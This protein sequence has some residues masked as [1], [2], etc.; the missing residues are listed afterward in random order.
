[1]EDTFKEYQEWSDEVV[2]ETSMPQYSTALNMLN[3][4]IPCETSLVSALATVTIYQLCMLSYS[5][6]PIQLV[7][8]HI[9]PI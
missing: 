4:L 7:R 8:S 2:M 9:I 6:K 1:M 3:K 5:N